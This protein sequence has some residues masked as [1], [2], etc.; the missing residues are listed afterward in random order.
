MGRGA[1]H[2][3]QGYMGEMGLLCNPISP[4]GYL[5]IDDHIQIIFRLV[6]SD[7]SDD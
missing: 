7:E 3:P 4:R 2:F 1:S 5:I 6:Y